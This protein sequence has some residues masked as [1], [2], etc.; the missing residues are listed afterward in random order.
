MIGQNASPWIGHF[1]GCNSEPQQRYDCPELRCGQRNDHQISCVEA[2][3]SAA[4]FLSNENSSLVTLCQGTEHRA[5][6]LNFSVGKDPNSFP[7]IHGARLLCGKKVFGFPGD[8]VAAVPAWNQLIFEL[9][10]E[11]GVYF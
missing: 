5:G 4:G 7:V 3:V 10:L 8:L 9:R 2:L 1:A 11:V 6:G